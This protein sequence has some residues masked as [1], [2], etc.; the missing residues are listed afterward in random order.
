MKKLLLAG[1]LLQMGLSVTLPVPAS[2][3][4]AHTVTF[5]ENL[6]SGTSLNEGESSIGAKALTLYSQLSPAFI[7]PNHTFVSWNTALNGT[8]TTYADGATYS[9]SSDLILYAQWIPAFHTVSF[10]QNRSSTDATAEFETKNAPTTLTLFTKLSP[11]F[12]KVGYSFSSWNTKA[13]GSGTKYANGATFSFAADLTLFAQWVKLAAVPVMEFV[14]AVSSD[15]PRL[16]QPIVNR[17]ESLGKSRISIVR[18]GNS[19]KTKVLSLQIGSHLRKFLT[20][21]GYPV[22]MH[23][24]QTIAPGQMNMVEVFVS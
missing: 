9:F 18:V 12:S 21:L 4:A 2:A 8:G 5:N 19:S 23:F 15:H 1:L 10:N 22:V 13:D 14:G 24:E 17:I 11:A 7:N 16:V 3:A 20:S 6:S